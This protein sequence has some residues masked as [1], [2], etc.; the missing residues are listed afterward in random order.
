MSG[1]MDYED[2]KQR[3]RS[4]DPEV[5]RRLAAE[6]DLRPELLYYL[7]ADAVP[8]V[9]CAIAAN[10]ATPRQ[11]DRLLAGDGQEAVRGALG[12]KIARLVPTLPADQVGRIERLTLEILETLARD[13]AVTVRR[14]LAEALQDVAQA[15]P[16]VIQHLARDAEMQV[17]GPVLQRSPVL[18]DEDLLAIITEARAAGTD[19]TVT[20]GA[21]RAIAG[22]VPV[23]EAVAKAIADSPDIAAVAVLL[24]NPSAQIR[25]ETLDRLIERAPRHEPWHAPLVHRPRLPAAAARRLAGF[26]ADTLLAVLEARADLAPDTARAVAEEVRRRLDRKAQA[27]DA[28]TAADAGRPGGLKSRIAE[29]VERPDDWARRL[30]AEGQLDEDALDAML[31]DGDRAFVIAGLAERCGLTAAVVQEVVDSQSARG[32]TALAWKANLTMRFAYKLQ[33]RLAHIAPGQALKPRGGT[34]W[35][36]SEDDLRWQLEFFG[37]GGE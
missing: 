22:R 13:Q 28:E 3:A 25:E 31:M 33:L 20:E 37:I 24:G 36:L 32:V 17:A 7:A 2:A 10:P 35:P 9:R 4:P 27:A 1:P 5:R 11:A 15:P 34:D 21:L 18:T 30:H 6:P 26:V 12:D 29:T 8:A 23:S 19:R 14:I 16:E